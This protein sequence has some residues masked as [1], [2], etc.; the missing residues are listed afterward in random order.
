MSF[1]FE[2]T[3]HISLIC[4]LVPVQ[5]QEYKYGSLFFNNKAESAILYI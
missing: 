3:P 2:K 1:E 4:K 5:Y